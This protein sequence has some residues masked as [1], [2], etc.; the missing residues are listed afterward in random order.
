MSFSHPPPPFQTPPPPHPLLIH[1]CPM[2]PA[3]PLQE[4]AEVWRRLDPIPEPVQYTTFQLV[5]RIGLKSKHTSNA[6][7]SLSDTQT[8]S[9]RGPGHKAPPVCA[10]APGPARA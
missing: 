8:Q 7:M 10:L 1:P 2:N 4:E 3:F 6:S 5:G 9:L